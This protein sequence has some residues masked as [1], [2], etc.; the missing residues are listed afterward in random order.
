MIPRI[1][2]D[3]TKFASLAMSQTAGGRTSLINPKGKDPASNKSSSPKP[4]TTPGA[5]S[6]NATP[7]PTPGAPTAKFAEFVPIQA[8]PVNAQDLLGRTKRRML[9]VGHDFAMGL[10][11]HLND[12]AQDQLRVRSIEPHRAVLG[13]TDNDKTLVR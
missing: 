12:E 8:A 10:A 9:S 4:P 5:P 1:R 6:V 2:I 13:P 3:P 7:A 11:D